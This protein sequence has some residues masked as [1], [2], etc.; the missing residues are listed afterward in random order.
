[1]GLDLFTLADYKAYQ[2]LT[3]PNQDAAI[4]AI[5]PIASQMV[6][7]YC[8]RT[9]ND[10]VND[11]KIEVN[12]GGSDKL[13]L[14]EFP[15]LAISSVEYSTDYGATF[16]ALA[17]FTEYVANLEEG[18]LLPINYDGIFPTALNGYKITYT[19]GY[20]TVPADLKVAAMDLL[21]YYLKNDMAVKAQR[22]AGA[23]T[24]QIE[25]ITK[26]TLPSHIVRV[27]DMYLANVS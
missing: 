21:T 9:F 10:F 18:Y 2:G 23:N 12:S 25:Y 17:E 15:V 22:A 4:K 11:A 26:N 16:I 6:K 14:S 19:G 13:Y 7:T 3:S 8:R 24:V 5:I 27:L 1:M 20:E